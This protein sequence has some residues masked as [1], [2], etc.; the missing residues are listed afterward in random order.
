L[1]IFI[2]SGIP[3]V[4]KTTYLEKL[5]NPQHHLSRRNNRQIVNGNTNSETTTTNSP[6]QTE[7]NNLSDA[8][9]LSKSMTGFSEVIW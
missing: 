9:L 4:C 6:K 2:F 1:I 5:K 3:F 8:E 7:S